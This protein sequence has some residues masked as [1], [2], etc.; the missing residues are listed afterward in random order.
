LYADR[1]TNL[2]VLGIYNMPAGQTQSFNAIFIVIFAPLFTMLWTALGKRNLEPSTPVKFGVS[3]LLVGLGFLVLVYGARFANEQ[4]KVPLFWLA[5][6]YL[7]H[8]LG[9]LCLSPVG[10]SMITK[11]SMSKVVGLM[12]GVWFISSAVAQYVGGII[13]QF[14][15]VETVGG[16]VTNLQE[17]LA[18]YVGVFEMIGLWGCGI[19]VGLLLVSPLL[20][21]M[22]HGIK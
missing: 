6:A 21:L 17:S 16:E 1:N 12:M 8:S 18:T 4:F 13:A 14:A 7:I 19:G 22:M 2:D 5:L 20:K 9:E 10:L 3:L 11:L 15:S